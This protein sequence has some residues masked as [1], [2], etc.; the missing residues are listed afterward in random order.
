MKEST[1]L[2]KAKRDGKRE[3]LLDLYSENNRLKLML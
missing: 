3:T 1:K 2:W